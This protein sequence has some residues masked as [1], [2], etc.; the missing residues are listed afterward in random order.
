[1]SDVVIK[2]VKPGKPR[3]EAGAVDFDESDAED[4]AR[5]AIK[6]RTWRQTCVQGAPRHHLNHIECVVAI[7]S[8]DG[9]VAVWY[10]LASVVAP[11]RSRGKSYRRYEPACRAAALAACGDRGVAALFDDRCTRG[12]E[13]DVSE[14]ARAACRVL[15]ARAFEYDPT[16]RDLLLAEFATLVGDDRPPTP[17]IVKAPDTALEAASAL[18]LLKNY[19]AARAL[20][21]GKGVHGL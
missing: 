13:R 16:P 17:H 8:P 12:G 18:L 4:W 10:G 1:M 5:F 20:L 9:R 21:A 19:A 7:A 11:T 3:G 6:G 2:I 15:H 14:L